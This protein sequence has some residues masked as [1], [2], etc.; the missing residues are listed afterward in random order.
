MLVKIY[1]ATQHHKGPTHL[2]SWVQWAHKLDIKDADITDI[3]VEY[4]IHSSY[5]N[6]SQYIDSHL[7]LLMRFPIENVFI[8]DIAVQLSYSQYTKE[9]KAYKDFRQLLL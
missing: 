6:N 7:T 8:L 4:P 2:K 1:L 5:I 3:H 9:V